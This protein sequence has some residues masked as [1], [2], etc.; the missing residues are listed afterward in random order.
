MGSQDTEPGAGMRPWWDSFSTHSHRLWGRDA[1]T[2]T[3]GDPLIHSCLWWA[4][5]TACGACAA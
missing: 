3:L 4:A 2:L 1:D 5:S